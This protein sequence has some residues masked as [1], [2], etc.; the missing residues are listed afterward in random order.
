MVFSCCT[1]SIAVDG[2]MIH[3]TFY[4]KHA[5]GPSFKRFC[6]HAHANIS[7]RHL[8]ISRLDL[9]LTFYLIY[10]QDLPFDQRWFWLSCKSKVVDLLQYTRIKWISYTRIKGHSLELGT[11]GHCCQYR[12]YSV[13]IT[14][15]AGLPSSIAAYLLLKYFFSAT[16][17]LPF[18]VTDTIIAIICPLEKGHAIGAV[19]G[20]KLSPYRSSQVQNLLYDKCRFKTRRKSNC[21]T[22][23]VSD[24][25]QHGRFVFSWKTKSIRCYNYKKFQGYTRKT[26]TAIQGYRKVEYTQSTIYWLE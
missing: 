14:K 10:H 22:H 2:A 12:R 15:P 17:Y 24:C 19:Q 26:Y 23:E 25:K 9:H 21:Y 3:I 7:L 18:I 20:F 1:C 8:V 6:S 13:P 5:Q 16:K 4:G 11:S